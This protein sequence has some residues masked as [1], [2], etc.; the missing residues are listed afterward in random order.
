MKKVSFLALVSFMLLFVPSLV[1]GASHS[2]AWDY[3]PDW[4]QI[5]GYTIY[6]SDGSNNYN[7]SIVK[8]DVTEDGTTV[9][10]ADMESNLNL[11][12]DTSYEIYIT[13][14]DAVGESGPSN[15]VTFEQGGYVP[16]VDSLPPPV[17][18]VPSDVSGLTIP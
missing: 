15:T 2:L 7:K 1:M 4:A 13:A 6:F 9:T 12:Y 14:Y 5:V 11:G 3:P 18:S 16:P 10:Y 8:A 17:G